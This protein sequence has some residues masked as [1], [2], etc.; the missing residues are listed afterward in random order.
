MFGGEEFVASGANGVI[1]TRLY[2]LVDFL[3]IYYFYFG[4][5]C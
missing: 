4:H 1:F 5:V 2:Q 3:L